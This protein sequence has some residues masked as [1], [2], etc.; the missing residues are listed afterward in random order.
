MITE[1]VKIPLENTL[2]CTFNTRERK[3][4]TE[5]QK[6]IDSYAQRGFTVINREITTK[7]ATHAAVKFTLQRMFRA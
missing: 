6:L 7:T 4:N 2:N 3:I 5:I 1:L